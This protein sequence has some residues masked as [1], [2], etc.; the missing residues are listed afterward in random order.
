MSD[1]RAEFLDSIGLTQDVLRRVYN[2]DSSE[3]KI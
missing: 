1:P 2:Q 3:G